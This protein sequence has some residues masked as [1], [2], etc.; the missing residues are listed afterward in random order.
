MLDRATCQA[1]ACLVLLEL[2]EASAFRAGE[3]NL[4]CSYPT[5]FAEKNLGG[6]INNRGDFGPAARFRLRAA[7]ARR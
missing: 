1:W 6:G 5:P 7:E 2:K 3:E 4:V